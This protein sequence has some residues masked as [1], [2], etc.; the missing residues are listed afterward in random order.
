[1]LSAKSSQLLK[2]PLALSPSCCRQAPH[3]GTTLVSPADVKHAATSDAKPAAD[4]ASHEPLPLLP[5]GA[6]AGIDVDDVPDIGAGDG[7][8]AG[9][10]VV[11]PPVPPAAAGTVAGE[12]VV[13]VPPPSTNERL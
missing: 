4:V 9:A 13:A 2:L 11:V 5:S 1:M 10:E 3:T 7:T 12:L 8:A 6:G